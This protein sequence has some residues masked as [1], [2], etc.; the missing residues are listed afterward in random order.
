MVFKAEAIARIRLGWERASAL[1]RNSLSLLHIFSN[2]LR[3]GQEEHLGT[4][5]LN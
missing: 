3:S 1:R 4:E 5:L 2:G